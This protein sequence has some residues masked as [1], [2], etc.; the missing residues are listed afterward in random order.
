MLIDGYHNKKGEILS[1]KWTGLAGSPSCDRCFVGVSPQ[2]SQQRL[3]LEPPQTL[4][5]QPPVIG[6]AE[7]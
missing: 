3:P 4:I 2:L 6:I 1:N 5:P 7:L